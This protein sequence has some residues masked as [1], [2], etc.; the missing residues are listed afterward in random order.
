[1]DI[2]DVGILMHAAQPYHHFLI[3]IFEINVCLNIAK[4]SSISMKCGAILENVLLCVIC[5]AHKN[6]PTKYSKKKNKS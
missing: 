1:M 2:E 3:M 4:I 5:L 6:K